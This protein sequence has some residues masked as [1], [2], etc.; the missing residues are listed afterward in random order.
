MRVQQRPLHFVVPAWGTTYVQTFIDLCLPAQMAPGNI[1]ALRGREGDRYTIYTT[2]SDHE[3]IARAPAFKALERW[4]EVKIEFLDTDLMALN[5]L[6]AEKKYQLKSRCYLTALREAGDTD[7]AVVALNADVL[8]ANGFVQ[9]ATELL[10]RGKRVIEVLGPRGLRDPIAETLVSKY[11]TPDSAILIEPAELSALWMKHRHP[12]MKMHEVEGVLGAAFHP[13]HLY[14]I[15]GDQGVVVRAFHLYPIVVAPGRSRVEFST[16]IDD[17]LVGNLGVS[18]REVF[19]AQESREMFVCELSPA[20]H[21]VGEMAK[22][23]D[24]HRYVD[25]YLSYASNNIRNLKKE[26]IISA[27]G[28]FGQEWDARRRDAARFARRLVRLYSAEQFRRA[29]QTLLEEARKMVSAIPIALRALIPK[30]L[31][32]PLRRLRSDLSKSLRRPK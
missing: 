18:Q 1:P 16:T 32:A 11:W 22:R 26:I 28:T 31:K 14:W 3:R 27:A 21:Y 8:L 4:I 2:R 19:V 30:P 7:A 23:G 5:D 25:F 15:V 10:A 20:D 24:L 29:V 17:D 12:L 13:S 9:R 6:A